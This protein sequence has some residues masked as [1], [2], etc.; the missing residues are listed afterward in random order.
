MKI[1][2]PNT[3]FVA[4]A[5]MAISSLF[6]SCE[7][8]EQITE[9]QNLKNDSSVL[10]ESQSQAITGQ[11]IVTLNAAASRTI[12][13]DDSYKGRLANVNAF[14]NEMISSPTMK[15]T[16]IKQVYGFAIT[17]F[18]ATLSPEQVKTLQSDSRVASVEPDVLVKL[19]VAKEETANRAFVAQNT[20][21][22]ITR[23]NGG[24]D[25][26]G[27]TAWIIDSGIDLDH[28]DLNVDVA[29]SRSF[30]P[31]EPLPDDQNGHGS[32]V[33]G[34]VAA[35]DNGI[36]VIGV[37]PNA[38]VVALKVLG[39]DGSGATSGI[40]AALD[41]VAAVG[42][43]GDAANMSLGPAVPI[44]GINSALDNAT[45]RVGAKGI[46][47]AIAAGNSTSIA[48]LYSPA[49]A[50]GAN[51]YTVSAMDSNDQFAYF[52][53][54]GSVVDYCA[55][56]VSVYSTS[57]QGGYATLSGTSMAAPHVC[58]LLLLGDLRTDGNVFLDPDFNP[59]PIAVH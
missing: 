40:I 30:V 9:T 37:A 34:T 33:A 35:I 7:A 45:T 29:R 59:D 23:V 12:S 18:T 38:K 21:Y 17:G 57:M 16:S 25:G 55:P 14:V 28:P 22:G 44:L 58:G 32:H 19:S 50:S 5:G 31:G 48:N 15:S 56:G 52:S 10:Q 42:E 11:Y 49:R 46:G 54:F 8:E 13:S 39:A 2:K 41:Y 26:T 36:G 43:P 53:N 51:V 47:V 3:T 24:V 1:F 27:K 6:L 20:P 4:L